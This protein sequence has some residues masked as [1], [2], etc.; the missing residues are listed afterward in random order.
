MR[1]GLLKDALR[2][3]ETWTNGRDS[4]EELPSMLFFMRNFT[5]VCW[6]RAGR[7]QNSSTFYRPPMSEEKYMHYQLTRPAMFHET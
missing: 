4:K 5:I 1:S 2:R 3:A 7:M 6:P